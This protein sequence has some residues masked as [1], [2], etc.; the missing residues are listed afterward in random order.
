[1]QMRFT[2]RRFVQSALAT[3]A[4]GVARAR[5]AQEPTLPAAPD[6]FIDT[7]VYVDHWPHERLRV[8]EPQELLAMLQDNNVSQAWAGSFDGLFY[9]DIAGVNERLADTCTQH[10]G[11][12][13]ISFGAVNP[14]LP[15]WEEDL[16][17][18]H[19]MFHMPGIRLH[20]NYHGY[21]LDDPRFTRLLE[22]AAGRGL[23]VQLVAW[24]DDSP[25]KWLTPN[26]T[27]VD[28]T[29]LAK[30]VAKLPNLQVVIAGGVRNA[31]DDAVRNLA[32][33]PNI[34]FDFARIADGDSLTT[35]V[36]RAPARR[37]VF[38]SSAPLHSIE[39]TRSKLQSAELSD[40]RR[41]AIA[42]RTAARLIGA[43]P[44]QDDPKT[45]IGSEPAA[46]ARDAGD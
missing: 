39:Y 10:G 5:A 45:F 19:E 21:T 2:R 6:S 26:A 42:N 18:C 11:G 8:D 27:H 40:E 28:L 46:Q 23:I 24:M 36:D 4:C 33:S 1:M 35:F 43:R 7:H 37:I 16:R 9:K 22:L 14:T 20:P 30:F 29:P 25:H 32:P 3:T 41:N 44:N 17:R 12:R 31:D 38:G 13:L 15:D 34:S